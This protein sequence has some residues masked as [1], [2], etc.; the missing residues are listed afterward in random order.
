MPLDS[1]P[2]EV[3]EMIL[4][5]AVNGILD[6][7]RRGDSSIPYT[8]RL[9]QWLYLRLSSR[10]FDNVLSQMSF[11]GQKLATLLNR[12]QVE[13][14]DF[15]LEAIKLMADRGPINTHF[16]VPRMKRL[17]GKIWH[18]PELSAASV[19][20][21]ASLLQSPQSLNFAV[22]LE[23]WILRHRARSTHSSSSNDGVLFFDIGDW[24]VDAGELQIRRV[25]RWL[26]TSRSRMGMYLTH[27]TGQPAT[28]VHVRL[29]HDRRWFLE[30]TTDNGREVLKCM[31]NFKTKMVWDHNARRL[32]DFEG[33][34]HEFEAQLS[35]DSVDEGDL[36][37]GDLDDVEETDVEETDDEESD[38]DDSLVD[39]VYD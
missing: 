24:V 39:H 14:L 3:Q 38:D 17:C 22:K 31:V 13:K 25:S 12:K 4:R 2:F 26:P 15:A 16:S 29:G 35:E 10:S 27:E 1:L 23:P 33:R 11:E 34:P 20:N 37:D 7:L 19:C 5:Y 30:F 9:R 8:V 18:N 28:P 6:D 21:I 36:F 32:Y